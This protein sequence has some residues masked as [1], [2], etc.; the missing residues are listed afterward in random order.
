[1]PRAHRTPLLGFCFG[2]CATSHS[3]CPK[4]MFFSSCKSRR[5]HLEGERKMDP[6][7]LLG[8]FLLLFCNLKGKE[9]LASDVNTSL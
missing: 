8:H 1:M 7:C 5:S 4:L 6:E 2:P 9:V 3:L